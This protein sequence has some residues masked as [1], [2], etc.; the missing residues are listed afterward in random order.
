MQNAFSHA[1]LCM[2]AI[3]PTVPSSGRN[4]R[5]DPM[6]RSF[7]LMQVV[8]A[9]KRLIANG[10]DVGALVTVAARVAGKMLETDKCAITN[11]ASVSPLCVLHGGGGTATSRLRQNERGRTIFY[12][13][14]VLSERL[15]S[16]NI[17]QEPR[18]DNVKSWCK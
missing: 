8:D 2:V 15:D 9:C 14:G 10:A 18:V 1:D 17:S 4:N 6:H 16:G 13:P 7:M 3:R 5:L 11:A 12:G